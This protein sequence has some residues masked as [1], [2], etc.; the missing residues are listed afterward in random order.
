MLKKSAVNTFFVLDRL[1]DLALKKLSARISSVQKERAESKSRYDALV[2]FHSQYAATFKNQSHSSISMEI[3]QNY[4]KFLNGLTDSIYQQN[5]IFNRYGAEIQSLLMQQRA[6]QQKKLMYQALI[7]KSRV[8]E[9]LAL[10]KNE[11]KLSDSYAL[12]RL[13]DHLDLK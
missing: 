13:S 11:Q 7:K 4:R 6:L 10:Q 8:R 9:Q 3:Y 1:T 2:S 5:S 12:R